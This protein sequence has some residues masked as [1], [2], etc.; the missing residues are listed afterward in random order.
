MFRLRLLGGFALEVPDGT[1]AP[2]LSQRRARA[3]LAVL[4]VCGDL[5]CTRER[6]IALLW[7]ESDEAHSRHGL[8]DALHAIRQVLGPNAIRSQGDDLL[9]DPA[10]VTS[11]VLEFSR[12]LASD[13][14]AD[15]VPRYGGPLLDGIHVDNASEF[16]HWLDGERTRLARQYEEALE[17]LAS[18]AERTE[19]WDAAVLWWRRLVEHDPSNSRLVLRCAQ[20]TY[21]TG[22]RVNALKALDAHVRWMR[23]DIGLEP[24]PEV[25]SEIQR[26]RRSEE[27]DLD[28]DRRGLGAVEGAWHEPGVAETQRGESAPAP[29]APAGFTVASSP[30]RGPRW[31]RWAV[32]LVLAGAAAALPLISRQRTA[33]VHPFP[34]NAVAV[35]PFRSLSTDSAHAFFASGLHDDVIN[36]L[37]RVPTL[38]VV[39]PSSVPGRNDS[40]KPLRQIAQELSVGSVLEATVQVVGARLRVIVQLVDPATRTHLWGQRYDRTV[41][42]ALAVEGDIA[43]QVVAALVAHYGFITID[44]PGATNTYVTGIN[45]VGKVVGRFSTPKDWDHGFSHDGDTYVTLDYPGTMANRDRYWGG[46]TAQSLNDSGV[47]V[48]WHGRTYLGLPNGYTYSGGTFQA[49]PSQACAL[50][51]KADGVN[52][53]GQIVGASELGRSSCYPRPTSMANPVLGYL[54][55]GGTFT[56]L[57]PPASIASDAQGLNNHGMVVGSYADAAG[58]EHG[59]QYLAGHFTTIDYPGSTATRAMGVNDVSQIVGAC[60]LADG[61]SHGFLLSEGAFT[62]IDVPGATATEATGINNSGWIVGSYT[63][64]TGT[65]HGFERIH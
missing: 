14:C 10:V 1:P 47:I 17:R 11:D 52:N 26:M 15:A 60:T 39:A 53:G 25:L 35:L 30:R 32:L 40:T 46:T 16:E 64:S 45:N 3:V 34:R 28:A 44:V 5:G 21:A 51:T 65:H 18:Q 2:E 63:D 22:D 9:L 48:G 4:A 33:P 42:N 12:D 8:R 6:L 59:F 27:P 56:A 20:A 58:T 55:G 43:R 24:V 57:A 23:E 41:D 31:S 50:V 49:V 61:K 62:M 36:Q 54:Y 19:R 38:K 37:A 13:R 29:R 7:P